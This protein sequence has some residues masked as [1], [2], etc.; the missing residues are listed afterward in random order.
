MKSAIVKLPELLPS[1]GTSQK[2]RFYTIH[3]TIFVANVDDKQY[4]S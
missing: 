3:I 1:F 2:I 4:Y